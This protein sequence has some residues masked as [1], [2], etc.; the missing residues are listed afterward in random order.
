LC[1]AQFIPLP[2][3]ESRLS[4]LRATLRKSPLGKDVDLEHLAKATEKFTGADLNEICQRAAKF[5]IR[6]SIEKTMER[7]RARAAQGA[8]ADMDEEAF[9]PVP[10][11]TKRHFEMSMQGARRSVSDQDLA[12]YSAFASTLQ[13]QRA[14]M[15]ASSYSMPDRAA[16]PPAA[17]GDGAG[18]AAGDGDDLYA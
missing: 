10:E 18:G 11:V 5:A 8:A 1:A 4:V 14:A 2:D 13:Q 6:E 17:G 12:K 15:G 3:Y 7:E 16:A 9:D